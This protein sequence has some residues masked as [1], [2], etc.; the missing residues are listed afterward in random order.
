M[1][2]AELLHELVLPGG[3]LGGALWL[4]YRFVIR[5]DNRE[6]DAFRDVRDQ[7]DYWRERC[8]RVEHDLARYVA[9]FGLLDA[10][11]PSEADDD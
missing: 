11:E 7:R 1:E 4:F 9:T 3:I 8:E 6:R 5:S 10:Q 2:A